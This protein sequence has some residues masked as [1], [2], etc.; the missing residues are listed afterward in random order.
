MSPRR[1]RCIT[2]LAAVLGFFL[3]AINR[4]SGIEL[5]VGNWDCWPQLL[6]LFDF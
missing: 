2:Y 3:I 4:S 6:L 1:V 5:R